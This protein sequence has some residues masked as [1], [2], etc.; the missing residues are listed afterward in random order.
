MMGICIVSSK[1][2]AKKDSQTWIS[3]LSVTKFLEVY[4]TYI[5][6]KLLIEIL[7]HIIFFIKAKKLQSVTSDLLKY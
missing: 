1:K 4:F 3:K 7:N 5:N 6:L 2:M